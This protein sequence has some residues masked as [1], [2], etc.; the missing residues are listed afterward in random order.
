MLHL[1]LVHYIDSL[2]PCGML[3]D[4]HRN[5]GYFHCTQL[6]CE[7]RFNSLPG[8]AVHEQQAHNALEI[9]FGKF[10]G[11][12]NDLYEEAGGRERGQRVCWPP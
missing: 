6:R 2:L 12:K 8:L 4:Q 5:L 1:S 3:R 10:I 7:K 11:E 9:Y